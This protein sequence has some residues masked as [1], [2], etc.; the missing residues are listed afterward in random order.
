[1]NIILFDSSAFSYAA[2]L[3]G[4]CGLLLAALTFTVPS[5]EKKCQL[6]VLRS[7]ALGRHPCP[8]ITEQ[9]LS[10]NTD[11]DGRHH[12][13]HYPKDSD[14][15]GLGSIGI[16]GYGYDRDRDESVPGIYKYGPLQFN[17]P[18]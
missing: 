2:L 10:S 18:L 3:W 7:M 17:S 15:H 6:S 16:H 12:G 8:L 4:V 5:D 1:M 13:R 9:D 11:R 14:S